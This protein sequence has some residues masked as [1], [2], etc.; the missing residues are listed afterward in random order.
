M[1]QVKICGLTTLSDARW[2]WRC[3][4]D[5]LGFIFAPASPRYIPPAR[6]GEVIRALRAEGC[7]VPCVGVFVDED[8]AVLARVAE[9]CALDYIQLHGHEPAEY[10]RSLPRPVIRAVHVREAL[11]W[12]DCLAYPAW[13]V[14]LDAYDPELAG[15][16]GKTWDWEAARRAP[17]SLRLILAGGLTPANVAQAVRGVRPWGVD[18]ASGVEMRPGVKDWE[19]VR[20]F[21]L[22]AK[23]AHQ[24][25]PS[26]E[27]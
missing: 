14:L 27:G 22:N 5:L 4:A 7:T 20:R 24:E 12:D 8:A 23:Y 6:A 26:E 18:V 9:A 10:A 1:T 25:M 21:I 16:T 2:A 3:G 15:G 19:K 13:A 17:A 11:E